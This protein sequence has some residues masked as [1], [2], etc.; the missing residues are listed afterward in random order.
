MSEDVYPHRPSLRPLPSAFVM[1]PLP[2]SL[3]M[4]AR[5]LAAVA[6]LA[7]VARAQSLLPADHV[8]LDSLAACQPAAANW[9]LSGALAGEPRRDPALTATEGTGVLV[10]NP[11]PQARAH[12]FTTWEHGDLDLDLDF[13]LTPG[14]NSGIYLQGRYEVQLFDSWGVKEPKATDCGGISGRAAPR[15]NA[16]RPRFDVSAC[17]RLALGAR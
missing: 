12:L 15:A 9:R 10:C 14:S 5:T 16:C 13:L 11:T 7:V 1:P 3:H 6:A 8:A 2:F 4:L 17:I